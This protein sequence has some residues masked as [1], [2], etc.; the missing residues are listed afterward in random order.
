[1]RATTACLYQ[2][3]QSLLGWSLRNLVHLLF[4]R[5]SQVHRFAAQEI[6]DSEYCKDLWLITL[7]SAHRKE[8]DLLQYHTSPKQIGVIL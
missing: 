6:F 7:D 3:V 5:V 2:P 8:I 1:M 4:T